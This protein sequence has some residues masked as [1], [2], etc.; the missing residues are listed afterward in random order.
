MRFIQQHTITSIP[1]LFMYSHQKIR[2]SRSIINIP[3]RHEDDDDDSNQMRQSERNNNNKKKL[4][5]RRVQH[6]IPGSSGIGSGM[7][8]CNTKR[9][10]KTNKHFIGL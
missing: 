2:F 4:W 6:L 3:L 9:N 1:F 8:K 7:R 10:E 5:M